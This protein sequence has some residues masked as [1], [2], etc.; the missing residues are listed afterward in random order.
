MRT[1]W[2]LSLVWAGLATLGQAQE[3]TPPVPSPQVEQ[4]LAEAQRAA[5]AIVEAW[6]AES[7]RRQAEILAE[8]ERAQAEGKPVPAMAMTSPDFG[9][10]IG[11]LVT[12]AD[13]SPGADA[14]YYLVQA[15]QF[16]GARQEPGRSIL[17]RLLDQH[18]SS[19]AWARLGTGLPRV[20][21][22]LGKAERQRL[23]DTLATNPDPD[24]RGWIALIVHSPE[25]EKAPLDSDRYRAAKS[26]L[27]AAREL[28]RDP[29]LRD[30]LTAPI[31]LRERFAIGAVSPDIEGLDLAGESF[32]LSD[33][34]GKVILL[35]FWGDW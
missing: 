26:A 7:A 2:M 21:Q 11:E 8:A 33:Y 25:V 31:D 4:R 12:W 10:V 3:P 17:T 27:L 6:R 28:A 1:R 15:L 24:V 32:R 23:L 5:D 35:S 30:E 22:G 9:P 14:A 18:A 29:A 16:G 34:R 13:A 20:V 19:P